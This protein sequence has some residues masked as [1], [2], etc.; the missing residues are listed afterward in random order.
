MELQDEQGPLETPAPNTSQQLSKG[1]VT[2][3]SPGQH[4]G[5]I[6]RSKDG[7]QFFIYTNQIQPDGNLRLQK[8]QKVLFR[9]SKDEQG[10]RA[11]D[12]TPLDS[13]A[14]NISQQT[15]D[16]QDPVPEDAM[17][18][19][20]PAQNISQQTQDEQDPVPEDATPLDSPIPDNSQQ[21]QDEQDPVPEDAM[22]LDS[23]AQNISQQFQGDQEMDKKIEDLEA[24]L[25]E[26]RVIVDMLSKGRGNLTQEI[27]VQATIL[28][29]IRE[30]LTSA[31]K[32]EIESEYQ[33]EKAEAALKSILQHPSWITRFREFLSP[34]EEA[35]RR[36]VNRAQQLNQIDRNNVDRLNE[37]E[38]H[39]GQRLNQL[40]ND[41]NMLHKASEALI[42]SITESIT[43]TKLELGQGESKKKETG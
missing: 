12:V 33:F 6:K 7:E 39:S 21:F 40:Y 4:F 24:R 5:C 14:Q 11:E 18:L 27:E 26:L 16:E 1:I 8:N 19:D 9:P 30:D 34:S 37:E 17:V 22:V 20:S 38:K 29:Q 23:P 35:K 32:Q 41:Q 28:R 10:P 31:Q 36:D 2:W 13:L 3:I 42:L 25:Q 43:G 15:Q